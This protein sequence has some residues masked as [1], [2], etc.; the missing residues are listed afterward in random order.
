MKWK[1]QEGVVNRQQEYCE[2]RYGSSQK[3]GWDDWQP[4]ALVAPPKQ[5]VFL[6][7]FLVDDIKSDIRSQVNKELDDYLVEKNEEDP[8]QYI[9]HHSGT[10]ANAYS[11]VHWSYLSAQNQ[12]N[13]CSSKNRTNLFRDTQKLT[14]KKE[15]HLTCFIAALLE[16]DG[17]FREKYEALVLVRLSNLGKIPHIKEVHTQVGF[18]DQGSRP[19]MILIL[20]D[21]RRVV[22]EHKIDAPE[23]EQTTIDGESVGQ[24]KSYLKLPNISGVAY[25]R[26]LLTTISDKIRTNKL[27][28]C[29]PN[30]A[31]FLWRDLYEPLALS[32]KMLTRWVRDSFERMGF[33]PP[34]PEI[35]ELWPDENDKVIKNNQENFGKL[36]EP[37][38]NHLSSRYKV[39]RGRRCELYIYPL[40]SGIINR[41]YVSPLA[42]GGSMLRIRIE[43]DEN[44]SE[45]IQNRLKFILPLL[46]VLPEIK[47]GELRNGRAF[48]DFLASLWLVLGDDKDV[49]KYKTRLSEQVTPILDAL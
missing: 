12:D 46:P 14:N 39:D 28:L 41:V 10:A 34:V 36:W 30:A 35:G 23:T 40:T 38:H 20:D 8:W 31:H 49:E 25:F 7:Q 24:I 4:I 47:T 48:L 11:Y 1:W 37:T 3:G 22:C 32:D 6:V 13:Y 42:Y 5:G 44:N 27:Y 16:L 33:T 17:S 26:P 21:N 43:T 2:I 45:E 18:A 9:K 19:D 15:D 29:P